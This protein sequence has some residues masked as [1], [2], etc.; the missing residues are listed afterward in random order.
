MPKD[1]PLNFTLL[2][3]RIVV[4]GQIAW[5]HGWDKFQHFSARVASYP[6]PLG[7]GHRHALTF[8]IASELVGGVLLALGLASR[9]AA[10]LIC[11]S[12]GLTLFTGYTNMPWS[13]REMWFL[14]AVC[15]LAVL[16]LGAGRF[17]LD[18]LVWKR[19]RKGTKA[20][21]SASLATARR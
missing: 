1:V 14:Y 21:P 19:F 2:L 18:T 4:G 5:L 3:L 12:L 10:L 20:R 7:I 13:M 11:A 6:D 9:P 17:A 15:T 8:A 16:F